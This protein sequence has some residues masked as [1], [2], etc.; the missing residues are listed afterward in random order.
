MAKNADYGSMDE[1]HRD[2]FNPNPFHAHPQP[3]KDADAE[4]LYKLRWISFFVGPTF[5]AGSALFVIGA[6]AGEWPGYFDG[7]WGTDTIDDLVNIP[8]VVRSPWC[9]QVPAAALQASMLSASRTTSTTVAA[10]G[11]TFC[12]ASV[13]WQS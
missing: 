6:A 10:R 8:Y 13:G 1:E 3:Y 7:T 9:C 5:L 11:A 2:V 4:A 12:T